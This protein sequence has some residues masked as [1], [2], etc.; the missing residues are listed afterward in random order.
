MRRCRSDVGTL[1]GLLQR[2]LAAR[3]LTLSLSR[4]LPAWRSCSRRSGS[5]ACFRTR[6]TRRTRELAVRAALGA[7]RAALLRLV[8]ASGLRVVVPGM[9]LGVAAAV[10]LTRTLE[11]MLV[12]V[13]HVD[14]PTYIVAIVAPWRRLRACDRGP[15][16]A[17]DATRSADR[18]AVGVTATSRPLGESEQCFLDC[19]AGTTRVKTLF[20]R[21]GNVDATLW[22]WVLSKQDVASA[23]ACRFRHFS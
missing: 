20:G 5:M 23:C 17:C 8:V 16:A 21:F 13:S 10:A 19:D 9:V 12:G 22:L 6:S 2:T 4:R 15:G 18:A 3:T 7:Q 14:A 1:D 11:S